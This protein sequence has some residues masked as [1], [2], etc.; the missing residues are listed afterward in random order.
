MYVIRSK[1]IKLV[2]ADYDIDFKQ[3]LFIVLLLLFI[4][5]IYLC[6]KN[7]DAIGGISSM[8]EHDFDLW[9]GVMARTCTN[10]FR[11]VLGPCAQYCPSEASE[12][13]MGQKQE[14][15]KNAIGLSCK[16][17]SIRLD[18]LII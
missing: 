17:L 15:L 18:D 11:V 4:F 3:P 6:P 13:K 8:G 7:V 16:H 14:T 9:V 10:N 1:S 2:V 5:L 12:Q